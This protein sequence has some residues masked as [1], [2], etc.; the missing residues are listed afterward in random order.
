MTFAHL[1]SVGMLSLAFASAAMAQEKIAVPGMSKPE[2]TTIFIP[3]STGALI[4]TFVPDDPNVAE[5]T[6]VAVLQDLVFQYSEAG[7]EELLEYASL[8]SLG[9]SL[10]VSGNKLEDI[11]DLLSKYRTMPR[12]AS[13]IEEL[14]TKVGF[15]EKLREFIPESSLNA[16]F[17]QQ[18]K[19]RKSLYLETLIVTRI[20]D[21]DQRTQ[22]V[23][24]CD[25]IQNELLDARKKVEAIEKECREKYRKIFEKVYTK[26][27]KLETLA[28]KGQ[29]LDQF[30]STLSVSDMCSDTDIKDPIRDK[31]ED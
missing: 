11:K 18:A 28:R 3:D 22:L 1:V 9:T 16:S 7:Y 19:T 29:S 24:E 13:G 20:L 10:G 4:Q 15:L 12:N 6:Q 21:K 25:A 2:G 31:I 17:R 23:V 27:Q 26:R 30:L 8:D 5:Q 14:R